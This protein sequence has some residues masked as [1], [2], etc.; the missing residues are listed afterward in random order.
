[1]TT[2]T[3]NSVGGTN[4]PAEEQTATPAKDKGKGKAKQ[5]EAPK[6]KVDKQAAKPGTVTIEG[7]GTIPVVADGA[8]RRLPKGE[9][10]EVSDAEFASLKRAGVKLA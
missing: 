7:K 3:F 4:K 6:A 9:P 10:V 5:T 2:T 8:M 1:M